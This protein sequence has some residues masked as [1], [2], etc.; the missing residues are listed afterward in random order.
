MLLFLRRR[1][2]IAL[3]VTVT[4]SVIGFALLRLSGD[5]AAALAGQNATSEE[6]AAVARLYGL[7]RPLHV[8]YFDWVAGA[9]RGDFGR[10]LFTQEPVSELILQRIGVTATL[11]IGSLL[12]ALVL[13]ILLGVAAAVKQGGWLDRLA[14]GLVLFGQAVPSFWLGLIL[15]I[16]FGVHLRWLPISG[17]QSAVHFILPSVTLALT[18]MPQFMRLTRS[19]LL[20]VLESDFIRVLRAKGLGSGRILFKHALPNA[21]LPVVSLS[22]VVLGFLV[23]GSVVIESVFALNG[24]GLLT[25]NSILRADFPVVQTILVMTSL[26][27]I[28]LTLLADVVNAWLAPSIRLH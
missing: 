3:L 25:F 12:L 9:L 16:T 17:S 21:I 18:V 7:D 26:V 5:L 8:Q 24:V 27:Y 15:I 2:F 19:G 28:V 20:E 6:I 1:L 13:G 10:S 14:L 23:G 22:A 4:V 11:A